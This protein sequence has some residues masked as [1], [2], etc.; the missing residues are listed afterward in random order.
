[1]DDPPC[2]LWIFDL[3]TDG[4]FISFFYELVQVTFYRMIRHAAHRRPFF[5]TAVF[6]CQ[7]QLQFFGRFDCIVIKHFVKIAQSIK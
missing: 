6:T 5:Q 3:F 1:M 7:R 2:M 4:D